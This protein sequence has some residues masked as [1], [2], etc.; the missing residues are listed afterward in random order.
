MTLQLVRGAR[1]VV[2]N[3]R[4]VH[5]WRAGTIYDMDRGNV[6]VRLDCGV[7]ICTRANCLS[8]EPK[9]EGK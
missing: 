1:V 4:H 6:F 9:K 8:S 3:P 5:A 2:S 7:N